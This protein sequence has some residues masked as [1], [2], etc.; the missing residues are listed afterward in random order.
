MKILTNSEKV[1]NYRKERL[2]QIL[3][4]HPHACLTCAQAEGCSR[5]QCSANVPEQ[6]RCC[7]LFGFCELQNL[8]DYIGI[9]GNLPRYKPRGL[10]VNLNEPL[11][12][13]N[14]ELCVG[15]LRCFRVCHNLKEI[16][17]LS[18]I[19]NNGIPEVG[20]SDGPTRSQSNCQFCGACVEV[21]PTG[22]LLDK[23]RASGEEREKKLVPCRNSCP[24]GINIPLF[25]RYLAKGEPSK[26]AHVIRERLPLVFAASYV[27]FHPCEEVCRRNDVNSAVSVCRLKRFAVDNNKSEWRFLINRED[28][29]G[30]KAA[31]IG[32]GPAGLTSA[33]YL[34]KKGHEVTVF[35]SLPHPGGMLRVGIPEFRYP[36]NIL[37]KDIEE[38]ESMGVK[39]ECDHHVDENRFKELTSEFDAV[40]IAAGAHKA[41]KI[42]IPG[43]DLSEV[44]WGV[45]FLRDRV[46][47]HLP[48]DLFKNKTVAVVGGGN[49]AMDSARV[50]TRLG[51]RDVKIVSLEKREEMPAFEFEIS[52]ALREGIKIFDSWGPSEIIGE[53]EH[54]ESLRVKYCKRVFDENDDFNPCFD[55]NKT[56]EFKVDAVI[57][58][59]G[60]VPSSDPFSDCG[61][62]KNSTIFTR[63]DTHG[64]EIKKVFAA[65]DIA[66]GPLSVIEAVASGRNASVEIDRMLGGDGNIEEKFLS[67]PEDHT[68]PAKIS[69]FA[70][71]GRETPESMEV[72]ETLNSFCEIEETY[73]DLTGREESKRCLGCDLRLDIRP[74][75]M[76]P[77][78]NSVFK[79]TDEEIK[80]IPDVEG[81][82][83]LLDQDKK[84]I[85]IKGVLNLKSGLKTE[86]EQNEKAEYFTF[87]GDPMY[88]KR[89][90]ELIQKYLQEFGELPG[91]GV[92]ELDDLF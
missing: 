61:L 47:G 80:N 87:E 83:K 12:N 16:G 60:Q 64:T 74:V 52:E 6:E 41:K 21:C 51:S 54:V 53:K 62:R 29:T 89:E 82:Y 81:V 38:I 42:R 19:I 4:Y 48:E 65:G 44:F 43:S 84:V 76:P 67:E 88:T 46:L 68:H 70:N 45:D 69:G 9:P 11:F 92:D 35:E 22:A 13:F 33:Y 24:V 50:S 10:P 71:M 73:S 55:E 1:K 57:L 8:S 15:C 49:V 5:T 40:L 63:A 91:G 28:S 77:Q 59:I 34:S 37:N 23:E 86:M 32:S 30:K 75:K 90:S 36:R 27:C 39:I 72:N 26:A 3:Y 31:V 14:P 85:S 56:K 18:F 25:L 7:E 78:D 79:L 17:A 20:Y 2:Y 58:A 66:S